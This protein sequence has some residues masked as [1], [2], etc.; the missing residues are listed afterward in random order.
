MIAEHIEV[1]V[2][3]GGFSSGWLCSDRNRKTT[4][5]LQTMPIWD[6]CIRIHNTEEGVNAVIIEAKRMVSFP[7]NRTSFRCI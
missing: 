6:L 5:K 7:K 3:I 1:V 4:L 2:E